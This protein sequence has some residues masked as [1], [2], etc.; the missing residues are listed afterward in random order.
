MAKAHNGSFN[1][2]NWRRYFFAQIIVNAR[3]TAWQ[4]SWA[5][6]SN[7]NAQNPLRSILAGLIAGHQTALQQNRCGS[8]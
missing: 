1:L 5:G 6:S 2:W 7:S 3:G 4:A 8:G